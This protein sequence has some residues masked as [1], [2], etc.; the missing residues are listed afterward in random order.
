M[1][2][3]GNMEWKKGYPVTKARKKR[4]SI[5]ATARWARLRLAREKTKEAAKNEA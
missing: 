1:F 3:K 5:S 4:M 2:K